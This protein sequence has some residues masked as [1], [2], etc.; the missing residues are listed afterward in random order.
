MMDPMAKAALI[1]A[2]FKDFI[3]LTKKY[4]ALFSDSSEE[5]D[6]EELGSC[7]PDPMMV[8]SEEFPGRP[9][10]DP[11]KVDPEDPAFYSGKSIGIPQS[12]AV[13]VDMNQQKFFPRGGYGK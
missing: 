4:E 9:N 10:F 6:E 8:S 11:S 2:C 1:E 5:E 7:E 12:V 13:T 3:S